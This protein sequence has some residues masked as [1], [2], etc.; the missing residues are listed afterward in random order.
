MLVGVGVCHFLWPW[1]SQYYDLRSNGES[2]SQAAGS[3]RGENT[4]LQ[5]FKEWTAL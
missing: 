1:D 5:V 4:L 3:N 2:K